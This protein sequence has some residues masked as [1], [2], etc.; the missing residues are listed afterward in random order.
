MIFTFVETNHVVTSVSIS[1]LNKSYFGG[2]PAKG[3]EISYQQIN[4]IL[5]ETDGR[6]SSRNYTNILHCW[7]CSCKELIIRVPSLYTIPCFYIQFD[8]SWYQNR[9]AG[10]SSDSIVWYITEI[11]P[12]KLILLLIPFWKRFAGA[13]IDQMVQALLTHQD[14]M[15]MSS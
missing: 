11:L 13:G 12:Y 4:S 8:T 10:V 6:V 7:G 3:C 1:V 9:N 15:H 2:K 14:R 5:K